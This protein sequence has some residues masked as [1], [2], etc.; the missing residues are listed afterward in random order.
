MRANR[1]CRLKTLKKRVEQH[2]KSFD[3]E[4]LDELCWYRLVPIE[5][6]PIERSS[7]LIMQYNPESNSN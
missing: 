1:D 6:V 3:D 7:I 2:H 4:H 5:A